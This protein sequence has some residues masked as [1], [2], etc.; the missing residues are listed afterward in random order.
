MARR[1]TTWLALP[2][3]A[4]G[5][6]TGCGDDDEAG[7]GRP[8]TADTL[9][10]LAELEGTLSPE[11]VERAE[12]EGKLSIYT[13]NSDL[14]DLALAF[15]DAYDV[16]VDVYRANSETVLARLLQESEADR[17]GV[18]LVESHVGEMELLA[19]EGLLVPYDSGVTDSLRAGAAYPSWT[20]TRFNGF[21]MAW[22][23]DRTG[24]GG[25]PSSWEDLAEDRWRGEVAFEIGDFDWYV[26]L[27]HHFV[28]EGRTPEEA[29]ALFEAMTDGARAVDGHTQLA[30][31]LGA[32]ELTVAATAFNHS[33]DDQIEAGAPVRWRPAVEPV[34]IKA[35][36]I[37]VLK[38]A[39]HPA[40]AALFYEWSLT[41]GQALLVEDHR[42]PA[43][44]GGEDP[45]ADV[46]VIEVDPAL[47]AE[48]GEKWSRR[49][50]ELL[51]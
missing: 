21:V 5:V 11:L 28:D 15:E 39:P 16:D 27:W 26:T 24:A 25:P 29:D 7:G 18:D 45:L 32:G 46:E 19:A 10:E 42:I 43:V 34:V 30:E 13:S 41:E 47:L 51:R 2:V 50:Q 6:L 1:R 37:G 4:L 31:L 35:A 38:D 48:E 17:G 22:N 20:A 44:V 12:A 3:L 49:Y 14:E 23:T 8:T 36:G 33:V 40:A 9:Q